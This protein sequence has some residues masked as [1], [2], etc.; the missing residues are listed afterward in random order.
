MS[1][2]AAEAAAL[3]RFKPVPKFVY[4]VKAPEPKEAPKAPE[5]KPFNLASV[6]RHQKFQQELVKKVLLSFAAWTY[7]TVG[8]RLLQPSTGRGHINEVQPMIHR[9]TLHR[10]GWVSGGGLLLDRLCLHTL[11][12]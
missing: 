6:E 11:R 3:C 2:A 12:A 7:E 5:F 1:K 10:A 4:E 9:N 8:V